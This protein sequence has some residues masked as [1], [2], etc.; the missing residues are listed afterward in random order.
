M[1]KKEIRYGI[2]Y[3]IEEDDEFIKYIPED[4]VK[5]EVKKVTRDVLINGEKVKKEVDAF[6]IYDEDKKETH[7]FLNMQYTTEGVCVDNIITHEELVNKYVLIPEDELLDAYLTN[8]KTALFVNKK[9]IIMMMKIRMK[10]Y[11][12][13]EKTGYLKTQKI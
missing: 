7:S 8:I 5:G 9:K 13:L 11:I 4:A 3:N 2:L 10:M 6:F 1:A 12:H